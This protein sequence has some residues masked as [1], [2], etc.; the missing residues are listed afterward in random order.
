VLGIGSVQ[1]MK[2]DIDK[3]LFQQIDYTQTMN[4]PVDNKDIRIVTSHPTDA[5]SLEKDEK[6]KVKNINISNPEKFW[7]ISK[8]LVVVKG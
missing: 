8:Y 5:Y 3:T 4:I 2:G 7:S 6:G 1:K